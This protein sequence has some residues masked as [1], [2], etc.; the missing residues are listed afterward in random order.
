MDHDGVCLPIEEALESVISVN[1]L[2]AHKVSAA[3]TA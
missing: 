1:K 2:S 3:G